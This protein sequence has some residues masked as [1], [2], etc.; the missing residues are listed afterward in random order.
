M[1]SIGSEAAKCFKQECQGPGTSGI[2]SE[3]REL[4]KQLQAF[5]VA[6]SDY[7]MNLCVDQRE[8][9]GFWN[10]IIDERFNN[11]FY[12]GL[13]YF[14]FSLFA[15]SPW[16]EAIRSTYHFFF[17]FLI[18]IIYFYFSF[19]IL[20]EKFTFIFIFILVSFFRASFSRR[21]YPLA[22][23]MV[24]VFIAMMVYFGINHSI[25]EQNNDQIRK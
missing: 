9:P 22:I 18:G 11:G 12:Q 20:F 17:S 21:N 23:T 25:T 24:M 5:K 19:L 15:G 4:A 13:Y 1:D 6:F 8:Q 3:I 7:R 10:H 16:A 14:F 2:R